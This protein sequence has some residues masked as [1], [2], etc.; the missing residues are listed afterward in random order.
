M[1]K[2]I[3]FTLLIFTFFS[4][5]KDLSIKE[6]ENKKSKLE[7]QLNDI[8]KSIEVLQTGS[9]V[10]Q[11]FFIKTKKLSEFGGEYEIKKNGKINSTQNIVLSSNSAGRINQVLV[12]EGTNVKAGQL[13]ASLEDNIGNYGINLSRAQNSLERAR[14]NYSSSELNLDKAVSDAELNLKRLKDNLVSLKLDKE[15]ALK[16]VAI[17]LE[18]SDYETSNS[19]SSLELQKLN[20]AIEKL[21]LDYSTKGISD[22]ETIIGFRESL[23]K[24]YNSLLLTINDVIEFS[25]NILGITKENKDKN[26]K[27]EDFL[28]AKDEKQRKLSENNLRDLINYKN[29]D[30]IIDLESDSEEVFL[31]NIDIIES[32]Y[33][34]T[35]EL[36]NNLEKTLN[37]SVES[38]G[39]LGASEIS[40]FISSINM[41]Q[42]TLQGNYSGFVIFSNNSKSFIRTYL[43]TQDSLLKQIE[44]LKKDKDILLKSL[45][46]GNLSAEI[47]YQKTL[48]NYN[49]KITTLESQIEM[50][51]RTLEN[52]KKTKS[53]TLRSL[54]NVINEAQI[55]LRSAQK[56]YS[57]L[58]I[59]S[60]ISGVVGEVLVDVG[61]EVGVGRQLFSVLN[62]NIPEVKVSFDKEE[63]KNLSLGDKAYANIDGKSLTGTLV[64]LSSIADKNL[65][66]IG[67]VTFDTESDLIGDVIELTFKLETD[68]V[69]LPL[70]I[71][72]IGNNSSKGKLKRYNFAKKIDD[73]D[74]SLGKVF[75]EKIEVVD[76][77]YDNSGSLV[78]DFDII[79]NDVSEFNNEKFKL[80][81][82]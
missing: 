5:S 42:S 53:I 50:A 8:E 10:K 17:Q 77:I 21:E 57:K 28:G 76:L 74:V 33:E 12:R 67:I 41:F 24:D 19:K 40:S 56:E 82:D 60:P 26:D 34:K 46:S 16:Q 37:N 22:K 4:C 51:Q 62:N 44:L 61:E 27:F 36:L 64:S 32:G 68:K 6:L 79:L 2:I 49:D 43:L 30:F 71:V 18:D 9:L 73:F 80:I 59:L 81:I 7:K 58:S 63:L 55:G 31:N 70:N 25:D 13:L 75:G 11:D 48:I 54:N 29:K 14:I 69:L 35:R 23:K 72:S 52:A 3:L 15:E 66:Y 78:E 45:S 20:N 39:T 65:K 47:S 1:K 38:F